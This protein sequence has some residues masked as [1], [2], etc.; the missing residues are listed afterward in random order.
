MINN[1]NDNNDNEFEDI[2]KSIHESEMKSSEFKKNEY[3]REYAARVALLEAKKKAQLRAV[4]Q[5]KREQMYTSI[6]THAPNL[7]LN[8]IT[9]PLEL[10][11]DPEEL[12]FVVIENGQKNRDYYN[13]L[14]I[15]K[16]AN[17]HEIRTAYKKLALKLHPDK[18]KHPQA[19]LAFQI[20]AEAFTVLSNENSRSNYDKSGLTPEIQLDAV[21]QVELLLKKVAVVYNLMNL[22]S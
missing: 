18:N 17:I 14:G 3:E 2:L 16:N 9:T 21:D 20:L 5:T 4:E 11:D 8:T 19:K 10:P 6:L 22:F 13:T 1:N 12:I 15:T 7:F